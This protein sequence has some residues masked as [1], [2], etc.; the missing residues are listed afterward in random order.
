MSMYDFI[1]ITKYLVNDTP[2]FSK[3]KEA[4]KFYNTGTSVYEM[5]GVNDMRVLHNPERKTLKISGSIPY[6]LNGQN[7]HCSTEEYLRGIRSMESILE[8]NLQA[9]FV[10]QLEFGII[11]EVA[12]PANLL[13]SKHYAGDKLKERKQDYGKHFIDS[14]VV[15]KVYNVKANIN[16]KLNSSKKSEIEKYG[17]NKASEWVKVEVKHKRPYKTLNNGKGVLVADLANPSFI[18][19]AEQNL[20]YEYSRLYKI[21]PMKTPATKKELSSGSIILLAL[22]E[23]AENTGK[24]T[25]ELVF[26][27]LKEIPNSILNKDDKKARRKQIRE[28]LKHIRPEERSP[29]DLTDLLSEKLQY[30]NVS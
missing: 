26:S 13:I 10:E 6:F 15:L 11:V 18:R 19:K 21:T 30:S 7:F 1:E 9:A 17:Y 12:Y 5:K 8:M 22:A 20:L 23:I 24:T 25:E 3:L 14:N 28:L 29:Y 16:H 4:G 2:N 27:K